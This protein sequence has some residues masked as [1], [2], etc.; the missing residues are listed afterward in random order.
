MP[1]EIVKISEFLGLGSAGSFLATVVY[2]FGYSWTLGLNLPIYFEPSDYFRVAI[3]WLPITLGA[4]CCGILL[5]EILRR[6]EG[7]ATEEE[8]AASSPF[9]R[10]TRSF[11]KISK[12]ILLWGMLA[13]AIFGTLSARSWAWVTWAGA[14]PMLWVLLVDWYR[15][16]PELGQSWTHPMFTIIT[17]GPALLLFALFIGLGDGES[18]TRRFMKPPHVKVAIGTPPSAIEG[19]LLFSL[20]SY[21]ILRAFSGSLFVVLQDQ[22]LILEHST[23][24]N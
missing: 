4:M 15:N 8:L 6:V 7:G 9:P 23:D 1:T 11:R 24:E 20:H 3:E 21:V 12:N 14:A 13:L 16:V 18:E 10:F 17:Y 2:V 5:N 19:N 22:V